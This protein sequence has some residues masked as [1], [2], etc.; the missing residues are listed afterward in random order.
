VIRKIAIAFLLT[1]LVACD[2]KLQTDAI[3]TREDPC[4]RAKKD[5]DHLDEL[6]EC[7]KPHS[8]S[9][10]AILGDEMAA[11]RYLPAAVR[12]I[13]SPHHDVVKDEILVQ[14]MVV[15]LP[16]TDYVTTWA[17][18]VKEGYSKG[19]VGEPQLYETVFPLMRVDMYIAHDAPPVQHFYGSFLN[20]ERFAK[21]KFGRLD[22]KNVEETAKAL[23]SG[24]A[25]KK[26]K[27]MIERGELGYTPKAPDLATT[28]AT[29]QAKTK[30]N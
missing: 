6:L 29:L 17:P 30:P 16:L 5:S 13:R 19:V 25:S 12:F 10:T 23:L 9:M 27:G 28:C 2:S 8:S 7:L 20:D 18:A 24:E 26:I 1:L 4:G 15:S 22:L 14:T 11:C 21:L 3:A